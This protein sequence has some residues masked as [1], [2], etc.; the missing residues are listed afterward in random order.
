MLRY[1][2]GQS[3][4]GDFSSL[5]SPFLPAIGGLP[6]AAY[7]LQS[8]FCFLAGLA[9]TTSLGAQKSLLLM[10]RAL[11]PRG[12]PIPHR[13]EHFGGYLALGRKRRP[14]CKPG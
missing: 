13:F 6:I 12:A 10:A 11:S 4:L 8:P 14:S 3:G 1:R 2:R 9:L 7:L 5:V